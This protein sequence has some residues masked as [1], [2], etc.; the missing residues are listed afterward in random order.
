M[1]I[2]H[3]ALG[4]GAPERDTGTRAPKPLQKWEVTAA[5]QV[6][7][8]ECGLKPASYCIFRGS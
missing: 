8:W 4:Q 2:G 5:S 7:M 6:A 1:G 3:A